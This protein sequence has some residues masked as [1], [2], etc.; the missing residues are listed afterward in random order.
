MIEDKGRARDNEKLESLSNH[1]IQLVSKLYYNKENDVYFGITSRRL[2]RINEYD[3][4]AIAY[5]RF[6]DQIMGSLH[7]ASPSLSLALNKYFDAK[8]AYWNA[9]E[10]YPYSPFDYTERGAQL[11]KNFDEKRSDL[12]L[13]VDRTHRTL[14]GEINTIKR[15]LESS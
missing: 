9:R 8:E 11:R 12:S 7:L 2:N 6:W 10:D 4:E 5:F 1:M 3:P 14:N 15:R 13:E